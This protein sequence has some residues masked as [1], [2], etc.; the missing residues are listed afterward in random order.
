MLK[1]KVAASKHRLMLKLAER[2][3]PLQGARQ[4]TRTSGD[5]GARRPTWSGRATTDNGRRQ[6][7]FGLR[8][9][10]CH[11]GRWAGR[12]LGKVGVLGAVGVL[13]SAGARLV[14]ASSVIVLTPQAAS[15]LPAVCSSGGER[16]VWTGGGDCS[17]FRDTVCGLLRASPG[18]PRTRS[19]C[20]DERHARLRRE[21]VHQLGTCGPDPARRQRHARRAGRR[22][23]LRRRRLS[24]DLGTRHHGRRDAGS[25]RR[26]RYHRGPGRSRPRLG[27]GCR[28]PH[29]PKPHLGL[30]RQPTPAKWWSR[31]TRPWRTSAPPSARGSR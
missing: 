8:I 21:R 31:A 30:R 3:V 7:Q 9:W 20:R 28:D 14:V 17:D 29:L 22:S 16:T 12:T 4:A 15:A 26:P 19:L 27:H 2:A 25:G 1:K 6:A 5:R 13:G 10:S 24:V 11:G 18:P 23:A